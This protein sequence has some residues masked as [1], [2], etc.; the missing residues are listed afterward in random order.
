MPGCTGSGSDHFRAK[1]RLR[2]RDR[3]VVD[4]RGIATVRR[5]AEDLVGRRLAPDHPRR[6]SKGVM[7]LHVLVAEPASRRVD[8]H[9]SV[10][11]S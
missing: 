7:P 4:L 9:R 1:F 10:E 8:E 2:G 11:V 6:R 3:A 5:H